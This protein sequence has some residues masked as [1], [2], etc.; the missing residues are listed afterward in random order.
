MSKN[1]KSKK[2]LEKTLCNQ[3]LEHNGLNHRKNNYKVVT[4]DFYLF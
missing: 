4:I 2:V 3:V 1:K